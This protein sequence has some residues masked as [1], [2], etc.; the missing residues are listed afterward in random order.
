MPCP[1]L[2]NVLNRRRKRK[3]E[4]FVGEMLKGKPNVRGN[5]LT[6][7]AQST[8]SNEKIIYFLLQS[9][10]AEINSPNRINSRVLLRTHSVGAVSLEWIEWKFL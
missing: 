8:Q 3:V 4:K 5:F 1:T 2:K 10:Q 6:P 9:Q 7:V